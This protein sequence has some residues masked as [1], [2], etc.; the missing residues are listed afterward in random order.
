MGVGCK[1]VQFVVFCVLFVMMLTNIE[2][3]S[4]VSEEGHVLIDSLWFFSGLKLG[5]CADQELLKS[6]F[7]NKISIRTYA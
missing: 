1:L 2:K 6:P 5:Q 4:S 3:K 7:Q